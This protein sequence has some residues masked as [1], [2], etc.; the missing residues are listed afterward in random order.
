MNRKLLLALIGAGAVFASA[1][2]AFAQKPE[3]AVSYRK[4]IMEALG[5]NVGPMGAMV[6][7]DVSFDQ[8]R[9]AFLAAR[10]AALSPMA[11]EAFTPDTKSAKSEA[12]PALWDNLDDFKK[13]MKAMD[14]STAKL[15]EAARAGDEAAIKGQFVEVVKVCK[16]CHDE[17]REKH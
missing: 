1:G 10:A 5:W 2:P 12:K 4:G 11:L 17:Y 15:A 14:E 13:R 8:D 7:G 16:G 3:D 9:F 6:K